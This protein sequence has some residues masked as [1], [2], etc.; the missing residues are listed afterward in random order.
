MF[1][2]PVFR[3]FLVVGVVLSWTG[4]AA[5]DQGF[6]RWVESFWPTARAAGITADTFNGAFYGVTPDPKVLE[7]AEYQPEFVRPMAQY[8]DQAVS[9]RRLEDG[10][11]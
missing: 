4:P 1:G 3:T 10:R 11:R 5:S 9:D 8:L 6:T 7:K 2:I